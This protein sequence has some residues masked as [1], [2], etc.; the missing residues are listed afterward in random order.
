MFLKR[1]LIIITA[2]LTAFPVGMK[3]QRRFEINVGISTPGLYAWENT[4]LS[5]GESYDFYNEFDNKAL[6]DLEQEAYK[7]SYHPGYSVEMA[8]K[9]EGAGF[10]NRLSVVG[11]A[12]FNMVSFSKYNIITNK[13]LFTETAVKFDFLFGARMDYFS[14]KWYDAYGQF[15][16]GGYIRDKSEYWD[17]NPNMKDGAATIQFTFLGLRFNPG[18]DNRLTFMT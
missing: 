6:V 13:P 2:F 3:S 17:I 4:D 14:R 18:E 16:M 15:L 8:Y 9:L 12:G 5:F 1:H 10:V 11:Y 7:S